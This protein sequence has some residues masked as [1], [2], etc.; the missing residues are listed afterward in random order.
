MSNK[1]KN[2]FVFSGK[3]ALTH[4]CHTAAKVSEQICKTNPAE[5]LLFFSDKLDTVSSIFDLLRISE[6]DLRNRILVLDFQNQIRIP[7]FDFSLALS[8]KQ[9]SSEDKKELKEY[10]KKSEFADVANFSEDIP[11]FPDG[12][13]DFDC[14]FVNL[15]KSQVLRSAVLEIFWREIAKN[16]FG[17]E[18]PNRWSLFFS[19]CLD[20]NFFHPDDYLRVFFANDDLSFSSLPKIWQQEFGHDGVVIF[21]EQDFLDCDLS[22]LRKQKRAYQTHE[23]INSYCFYKYMIRKSKYR[24]N[25]KS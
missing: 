14:I 25:R 16:I 17:K 7:N 21:D 19:S 11:C 9:I 15:P 8:S 12:L 2:N 20:L 24:R 13:E 5:K 1:D 18:S 10:L 3:Y 23:F 4:L 6:D 22:E